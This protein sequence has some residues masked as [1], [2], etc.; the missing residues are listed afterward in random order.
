MSD[1]L[2]TTHKAIPR[3]WS[4]LN[5]VGGWAYAETGRYVCLVCPDEVFSSFAVAS[6][7]LEKSLQNN[8]DI[9]DELESKPDVLLSEDG[10]HAVRAVYQGRKEING[11]CFC[12]FQRVKATQYVPPNRLDGMVIPKTTGA[13]DWLK[14]TERKERVSQHQLEVPSTRIVGNKAA[15][16]EASKLEAFSVEFGSILLS[17]SIGDILKI[18][19]AKKLPRHMEAIKLLSSRS[20]HAVE[21]DFEIWS[22]DIPQ[23]EPSADQSV[24]CC[25]AANDINLAY[26]A[27]AF[28]EQFIGRMGQLGW[29]PLT[30]DGEC[31]DEE[32]SE[33]LEHKPANVEIA[34]LAYRGR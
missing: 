28:I 23:Q 1:I 17:R 15:L 24:V 34:A 20:Q 5:A 18:E 32:F 11:D 27:D 19:G 31:P 3:W 33:V 2:Y 30:V 29:K 9:L 25:L 7:L 13:D 14:K 21:T 12:K 10:F 6:A 4:F 26:K 8:K 16:L 22:G